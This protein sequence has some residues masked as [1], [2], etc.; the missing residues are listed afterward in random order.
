[1][2]RPEQISRQHA[3]WSRSLDQGYWNKSQGLGE[4][5]VLERVVKRRVCVGC[6]FLVLGDEVQ[7]D[8]DQLVGLLA[9]PAMLADQACGQNSPVSAL[10][11][12]DRV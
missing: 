8:R 6:R 2:G 10:F 7:V 5:A 9:G 1:M 3:Q 12:F 11:V 4:G